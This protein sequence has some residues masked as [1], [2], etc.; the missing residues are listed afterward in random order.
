[1]F[2]T[3]IAEELL[4]TGKHV[5]T[6]LTRKDS[7]SKLAKGLKVVPVDYDNEQTIIDALQGQQFLVITMSVLAPPETHSKLVKA[8]GKAG[9]P[10]VM[11]NGYGMDIQNKQ[12][13]QEMITEQGLYQKLSEIEGTGVS[14]WITMVCGLWYEYSLTSGPM[15]LG[16]DF[17]E[18][19][20]LF[21]DDGHTKITITTWEQC[22]RAIAALVSLKELP[23]DENDK[24]PSVS[25]WSNKPLYVSSF[26]ISQKDMFE[27]WKRV[28]G[29][30]DEDWKFEYEP[31]KEGYEKNMAL[32]Q[33]KQDKIALF[34]AVFT[35]GFYQNGDG[36]TE[37][38]AQNRLLGLPKED[39]D[40]HTRVAKDIIE[41]D[42]SYVRRLGF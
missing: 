10:Y 17:K 30:K 27:S 34:K 2:G 26:F 24:S 40:E 18:K 4:K 22:A 35:R 33:Q 37:Q 6:A 11:P 13:I 14:S 25:S 41:R 42:F 38:K 12:L 7:E 23:E 21:H 31:S 9:I 36:N 28:S 3:Y 5:V 29:D 1:M 32:F 39:L 16:F 20:I 15:W 8:A 19:K